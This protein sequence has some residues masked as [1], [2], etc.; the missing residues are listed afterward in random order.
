MISTFR[1]IIIEWIRDHENAERSISRKLEPGSNAMV[2][3]SS[4]PEKH[5]VPRTSTHRGIVIDW[6]LET[7]NAR[8][9]I[10]LKHD[11][12]SNEMKEGRSQAKKQSDPMISTPLGRTTVDKPEKSR[13]NLR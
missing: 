13:I 8:A 3:E 10:N 5:F 12:G 7:K 4:Q 11:S 9:S 6:R 1:G 2:G